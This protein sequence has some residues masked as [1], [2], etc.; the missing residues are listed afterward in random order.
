MKIEIILKQFRKEQKITLKQL[1]FKTGV[2]TTHLNDIENGLK[3]PGLT[4]LVKIALALNTSIEKLI[5][6][7]R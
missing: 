6:I 4:V 3:E 2:S 5:K 1:S 7:E